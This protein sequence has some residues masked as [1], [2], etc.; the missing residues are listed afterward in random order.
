MPDFSKGSTFNQD[1]NFQG[2]KFGADAPLLETELNEL[3]DIQTEARADIIRDTIPSGFVQLGELD[4]DYM[5]NN[6]NCVKLKTDSVAYVN[7]Y[8][9][10][11]PKDTIIDIGRAP[12][13]DAREDLL[14]LEV[15][16]EEVTK[17][18]S[19]TVAGGEGQASIT[20]AILDPR[21]GQETSRRVA[22]KWRIRLAPNVDFNKV[23]SQANDG[24]DKY[25]GLDSYGSSFP[26]IFPQGGRLEPISN[27]LWSD[28]FQN[29]SSSPKLNSNGMINPTS[30]DVGL[31]STMCYSNTLEGKKKLFSTLDGFVYAIPMFRLY[32]KPSCGKSKPFEYQKINPKVDYS[33]ATKIMMDKKIE[34]VNSVEFKGRTLLNLATVKSGSFTFKPDANPSNGFGINLLQNMK[35]DVNYTLILNVKKNTLD[36]GIKLALYDST[37]TPN[38]PNAFETGVNGIVTRVIRSSNQQLKSLRLYTDNTSVGEVIIDDIMVLEGDWTNLKLPKY[39]EGLKS[40]S[41]DENNLVGVKNSILTESSYDPSI[42]NVK[43]KLSAGDNH[44]L[45]TNLIKPQIE[46]EL[47]RDLSKLSDITSFKK[48]DSLVGDEHINFVKIKGKTLHNICPPHYIS[49]TSTNDFDGYNPVKSNYE[50][51]KPNTEYTLFVNVK[52]FNPINGSQGKYILNNSQPQNTFM[53]TSIVLGE[54]NIGINKFLIKSQQVLPN[55]TKDSCLI[56]CQNGLSR[57][58]IEITDIIILEGNHMDVPLSEVKYFNGILSVGESDN[59]KVIVKSLGKNITNSTVID[60]KHSSGKYVTSSKGSY[61]SPSSIEYLRPGEYIFSI[62]GIEELNKVLLDASICVWKTNKDYTKVRRTSIFSS[63]TIG[64]DEVG[65]TWYGGVTN[66]G[67]ILD[68]IGK[69]VQIAKTSVKTP[70]EPYKEYKQEITLKEPLRSLPSGVC[71]TIEGNKVIRRIKKVIL[72]SSSLVSN[73]T[74]NTNIKRWAFTLEDAKTNTQCLCDKLPYVNPV[75]TW[76]DSYKD[77]ISIN[78]VGSTLLVYLEDYKGGTELDKQGLVNKLGDLTIYYELST[79]IEEYIEPNYDKESIVTYQLDAPLRS[80]PSGDADEISKD[81]LTRRCGEVE[82]NGSENWTLS[83]EES[84]SMIF[85]LVFSQP[86]VAY[87]N[88]VYCNRFPGNYISNFVDGSHNIKITDGGVF[89]SILKSYLTTPNLDGFKAW[90][91]LNPLEV[92]YPLEYPIVKDL[93]EVYPNKFVLGNQRLFKNGSWLRE[94]PN[95]A[96]D[97]IEGKK[98]I[99]RVK[100]ITFTG[101]EEWVLHNEGVNDNTL[102]FHTSVTTGKKPNT[103]MVSDKFEYKHSTL[104]PTTDE[105]FISGQL[106]TSTIYIRILKSKLET[107]DATG[108]K[109]WLSLNPVKVLYE[110]QTPTEEVLTSLNNMYPPYHDLNSYCGSLYVGDGTNDLSVDSVI[111]TDSIIVNSDFRSIENKGVVTNCRYKKINGNSAEFY[112]GSSTVNLFNG[113]LKQGDLNMN[114]GLEETGAS[115]ISTSYT[116]VTSSNRYTVWRDRINSYALGLRYYDSTFK[117][118]GND[119]VILPNKQEGSFTTPKNCRYVKFKDNTPFNELN[120]MKYQIQ[121]GNFTGYEPYKLSIKAFENVEENDIDDLRHCVSLTGFSYD[122]ML[123]DSFDKLLR[124]EL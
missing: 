108:F 84:T 81:K 42:G 9:I 80:L 99:R 120:D 124:G 24:V 75:Y 90:L 5:L 23:W 121:L 57:A 2:V 33:K 109:K 18:S 78:S 103:V 92:V 34:K 1:A 82:L 88:D 37:G 93:Y 21:V 54:A 51:V 4:F 3:Q 118:L 19:L 100:S 61:S 15:W 96:K 26:N 36:K 110:L 70:Y 101:T 68:L 39:F 55:I 17:D 48:L 52:K 115:T 89:V 97:K 107:Q 86:N 22:L 111:K 38:Y 114:T 45:S 13:I 73:G 12:E 66:G 46:A 16:K 28:V 67:N 77:G 43:L 91:K 44:I 116:T 87:K 113:L 83:R 6:E 94:I 64:E 105:E 50:L 102:A 31:W 117:Y 41:E 35:Q 27:P 62:E 40:L 95:G 106:E 69:G 58:E 20:N 71:D 119:T 63:F 59:N 53:E 60:M 98:V 85:G 10:K 76:G 122:K 25:I 112:Y 56:R 65:I 8:K 79:P 47:K 30:G 7:G 29:R 74:K 11:I 123:N 32:R 104:I 14:F 72:P 49:Y